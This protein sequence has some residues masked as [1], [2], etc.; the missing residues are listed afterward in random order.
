VY[1]PDYRYTD[2]YNLKKTD[3]FPESSYTP[4]VAQYEDDTSNNQKD[5]REIEDDVIDRGDVFLVV[6]VLLDKCPHSYTNYDSTD[7]LKQV[8]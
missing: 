1:C 7:Q 3:I 2:T 6:P 5:D 4:S 8:C